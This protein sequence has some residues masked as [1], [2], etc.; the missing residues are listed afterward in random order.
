M[1]ILLQTNRGSGSTVSNIGTFNNAELLRQKQGAGDFRHA[2][3]R[4][5]NN[6]ATFVLRH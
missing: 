5:G 6:P 3:G 2:G 1:K 4:I